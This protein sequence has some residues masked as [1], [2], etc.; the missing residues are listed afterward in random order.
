M[1]KIILIGGGGHCVSC[2]DAIE[3]TG[4]FQ[5]EG[6][7]DT[8]ENIGKDILGYRV[9]G[10]DDDIEKYHNE[11]YQFCLTIGQITSGETL[12]SKIFKQLE[13][14]NVHLPV[15]ISSDASVSK[16]AIIGKG[17]VILAGAR[18]NAG[19][20]IGKNCIINSNALVEHGAFVGNHT[21]V[22]T[23]AIINGDCKV[24]DCCFIGSGAVLRNGIE[25]TDDCT[26]GMGAVM[27]KSSKGSGIYIGAPA[28]K[29]K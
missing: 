25:V 27:T 23:G 19:A 22:S 9:I 26:V 10:T 13:T 1:R 6:I 17:A 14:I 15:I 3:S 21:H 4:E 28:R 11:G 5:I 18:V 12:R 29:M 8:P 2:I 24:M 16:H 20:R 7:L